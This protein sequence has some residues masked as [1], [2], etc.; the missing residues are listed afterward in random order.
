MSKTEQ[1][2]NTYSIVFIQRFCDTEKV[3]NFKNLLALFGEMLSFFVL[4]LSIFGLLV[5]HCDCKSWNGG[6][7]IQVPNSI[8][9]EC[10][11]LENV[12]ER[13]YVSIDFQVSNKHCETALVI[14]PLIFK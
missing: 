2:H 12:Q 4:G 10:Y 7:T 8:E 13:Y 3:Q 1:K 5:L 6:F 9:H 14:F 11:F